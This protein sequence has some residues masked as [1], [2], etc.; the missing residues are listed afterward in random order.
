MEGVSAS[1][2][3]KQAGVVFMT[4]CWNTNHQKPRDPKLLQTTVILKPFLCFAVVLENNAVTSVAVD[5]SLTICLP[6][7]S[8]RPNR[9]EQEDHRVP[10]D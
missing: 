10:D 2:Q 4:A 9:P 8:L 1:V 5:Q 7:L 3:H 6:L